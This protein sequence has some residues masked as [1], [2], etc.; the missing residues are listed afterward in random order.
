M[1]RVWG[2]N[3]FASGV[4]GSGDI[5]LRQQLGIPRSRT[6]CAW[7]SL[8]ASANRLALARAAQ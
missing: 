5:K 7:P 6:V 1:F 4:V 2:L 3:I 8:A